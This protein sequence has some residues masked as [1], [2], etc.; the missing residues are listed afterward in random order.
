MDGRAFA[1]NA[2]ALGA[3][4]DPSPLYFVEAIGGQLAEV[5]RTLLPK[6]VI[7]QSTLDD[8]LA[9]SAGL[10]N[11]KERSTVSRIRPIRGPQAARAA[12]QGA[13]TTADTYGSRSRE[14]ESG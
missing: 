11:Q 6:S 4:W 9:D 2:L 13:C 7:C 14:S 1:S 5:L 12:F 3:V 10:C 8:A